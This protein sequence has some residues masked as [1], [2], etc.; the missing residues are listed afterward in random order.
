MKT[1]V[2]AVLL[3]FPLTAAAQTPSSY[4]A[5]PQGRLMK[6]YAESFTLVELVDV[7]TKNL[8]LIASEAAKGTG[9]EQQG[10]V[11]GMLASG[12]LADQQ[13]ALDVAERLD[14]CVKDGITAAS[15]SAVAALAATALREEVTVGVTMADGFRSDF[16]RA[17]GVIN[18]VLAAG[19]NADLQAAANGA[20]SRFGSTISA[21]LHRVRIAA[22]ELVEKSTPR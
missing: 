1:L 15:P 4:E 22:E 3:L 9:A 11:A 8:F 20:Y 14:I 13:Q 7:A 6:C 17:S 16:E 18:A 19:G 21:T 2:L 12:T 5:T 10:V